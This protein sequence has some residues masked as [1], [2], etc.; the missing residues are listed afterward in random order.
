MDERKVALRCS[1]GK[2]EGEGE[3]IHIADMAERKDAEKGRREGRREG[4]RKGRR[5]GGREG[6]RK[7]WYLC[8]LPHN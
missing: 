3:R 2:R 8:I 7:P 5:E 1:K 6:G 4:R